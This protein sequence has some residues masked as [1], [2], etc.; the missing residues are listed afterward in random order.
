MALSLLL[1]MIAFAQPWTRHTIDSNSIGADGVKLGDIN[2]DGRPDITT[3]WE[4]GGA[5]G[6]YRNPGPAKA[7]KAWPKAI[8]GYVKAPEDAGFTD[9]DGYAKKHVISCNEGKERNGYVHCAP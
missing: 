5:I 1:A 3:A 4:E 9:I 8:A 6:V 7:S 2:G